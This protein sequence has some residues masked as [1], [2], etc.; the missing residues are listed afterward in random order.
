MTS[1]TPF[2]EVHS[3]NFW[4]GSGDYAESEW[5]S[6]CAPSVKYPSAIAELYGDY[7]MGLANEVSTAG[8]S[9]SGGAVRR[10]R[11]A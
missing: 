5:H 11:R 7:A 2:G 1:D 3:G 4:L 9:A 6:A 8:L 10:L